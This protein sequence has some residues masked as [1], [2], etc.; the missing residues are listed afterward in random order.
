M[1]INMKINTYMLVMDVEKAYDKADPRIALRIIK[2][3]GLKGRIVKIIKESTKE[4]NVTICF[5][6]KNVANILVKNNIKQGGVYSSS[7][8]SI[9]FDQ[10]AKKNSEKKTKHKY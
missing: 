4:N 9:L 3:S 7:L 6:R 8:F 5:N 10:L 1:K 2:N